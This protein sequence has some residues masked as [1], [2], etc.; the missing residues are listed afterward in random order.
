[1]CMY[2]A[3]CIILSC[4]FY[5]SLLSLLPLPPFLSLP[6]SASFSSLPPSS[7]FPPSLRSTYM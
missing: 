4:S 6:F 3:L 1:M 7:L 5:D 2:L